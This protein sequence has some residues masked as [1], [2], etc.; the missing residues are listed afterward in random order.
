V[1]IEGRFD[2]RHLL[3]LALVLALLSARPAAAQGRLMGSVVS[4]V[5]A[6][7]IT[8]RL[9]GGPT[10]TVRLI[11]IEPPQ[12][13]DPTAP[14]PCFGVEAAARTAEL[15]PPGTAVGLE[16]EVQDQDGGGRVLAYVWPTDGRPMVNEQLIAEGFARARPSPPNVK[17]DERFAQAQQA[18]QHV[19]L[20]LWMACEP[21]VDAD[22]AAAAPAP[23]APPPALAPTS[24]PTPRPSRRVATATPAPASSP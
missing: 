19:R 16:R 22:D 10:V 13:A 17:Y 23:D 4:V 2:M 11:G 7:T 9:D 14:P 20:G 6:G 15:L 18:A 12:A 1:A 8:V 3:E 24:T 5:D 21:V